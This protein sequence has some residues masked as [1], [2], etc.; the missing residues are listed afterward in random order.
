MDIYL[1]IGAERS[2]SREFNDHVHVF[3]LSKQTFIQAILSSSLYT[4]KA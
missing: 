4:F 3:V 2:F 1:A